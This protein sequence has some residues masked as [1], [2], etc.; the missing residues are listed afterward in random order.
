M[1]RVARPELAVAFASAPDDSELAADIAG[2][3]AGAC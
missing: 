3:S 1:R 2:F